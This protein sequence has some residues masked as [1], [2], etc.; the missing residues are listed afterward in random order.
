MTDTSPA[1]TGAVALLERS[2]SYALGSTHLIAPGSLAR[3]TPCPGWDLGALLCHLVDALDAL[4]W[5]GTDGAFDLA[6]IPPAPD[7]IVAV[8]DRARDVIEIWSGG[9]P[10]TV[11]VGGSPL[12]AAIVVVAGAIEVAVHGWDIARSCGQHRPIPEP[13]AEEMLDL[14][15][16]VV[17]IAER[18]GRFGPPIAVAPGAT[19]GDRLI[20][21]LGRRPLD[22]VER[23]YLQSRAALLLAAGRQ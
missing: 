11:A 4:H 19:A 7:P 20:A 18:R 1:L 2:I 15:P 16:L 3:P 22:P 6:S 17:T 12:S 23:R 13:L 9:G 8:R 10:H 21:F 5:A 14:V